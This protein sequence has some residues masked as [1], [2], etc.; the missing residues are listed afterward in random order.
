MRTCC[1]S[2]QKIF[3]RT[4]DFE[5]LKNFF[6]ICIIIIIIIIQLRGNN[7]VC[8]VAFQLLRG[9]APVQ[10]RRN[11][12]YGYLGIFTDWIARTR[13]V[14]GTGTFIVIMF[15]AFSDRGHFDSVDT[16]SR[17][18]I[19]LWR[20]FDHSPLTPR[21]GKIRNSLDIAS[22]AVVGTSLCLLKVN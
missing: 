21:W 19:P 6:V 12:D 9:R 10:L 11:I 20:Q 17:W 3:T 15:K 14:V 16:V 13:L 18:Q 7:S 4:D 5:A 1:C 2:E 8:A 22:I